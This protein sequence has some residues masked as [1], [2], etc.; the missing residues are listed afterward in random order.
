MKK[1]ASTQ[2]VEPARCAPN[3]TRRSAASVLLATTI[4]ALLGGCA[5]VSTQIQG[6]GPDGQLDTAAHWVAPPAGSTLTLHQPLTIRPGAA[7]VWIGRGAPSDFAVQCNLEVRT[8]DRERPQIIRPDRFTIERTQRFT[9]TVERRPSAPPATR[10]ARHDPDATSVLAGFAM[11]GRL[12]WWA[13]YDDGP[14]RVFE[15]WHWYVASDRQ[16][17]VY[18]LNCRGPYADPWEALPPSIDEIQ[19]ALGD[20]MTLDL[21]PPAR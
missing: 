5:S 4:G 2:P 20:V 14:T 6:V 19:R 21:A 12:G 8:L 16:P 15:G 10:Y 7:R 11:W 3:R 1:S 9:T 13:D 17:D 18:R